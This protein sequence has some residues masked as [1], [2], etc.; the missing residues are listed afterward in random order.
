[1]G[2]NK[3][4]VGKR[5]KSLSS[6]DFLVGYLSGMIVTGTVTTKH[7]QFCF[8]NEIQGNEPPPHDCPKHYTVSSKAI[9]TDTTLSLYENLF[10]DFNKKIDLSHIISNDKST[11]IAIIKYVS[12]HPK[13]RLKD[14]I[15]QLEW[16]AILP[17]ELKPLWN[18]S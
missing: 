14:K 7:W 6:C 11:M 9:E 8:S 15:H 10:N 4:S 1:M 18:Q 2:R 12:N 13:C 3:R 5:Y 17:P 16:Y